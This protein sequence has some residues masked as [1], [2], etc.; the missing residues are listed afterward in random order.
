MYATSVLLSIKQKCIGCPPPPGLLTIVLN[1][2]NDQS[3]SLS[4]RSS[5]KQL[6]VKGGKPHQHQHQHQH[7]HNQHPHQHHQAQWNRAIPALEQAEGSFS[8]A[9]KKKK[10]KSQSDVIIGEMRSLLNKVT[11]ENYD[12]LI[13]E[14]KK[15][16]HGLC[17]YANELEDTDKEEFLT[18]ISKLFVRKAQVDHAFGKYYA[19]LAKATADL[20]DVFAD[21]LYEVCRESIPTTKYDADKKKN[22][23]G[24]L[25]LLV[26]LRKNQII[27]SDN[28]CATFDRL[29]T[30]IE[31]CDPS[32]VYSVQDTPINPAEQTE[33][34]IDIIVTVLP[35]YL[36]V[37]ST[38]WTVKHLQ[39]L[40]ALQDQT[41]RLKQR[42][43][44]ILLDFFKKIEPK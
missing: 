16:H 7:H 12:V 37:E 19:G 2:N 24:A 27:T 44:F 35:L 3:S 15:D 10:D 8:V 32:T 41:G 29:I 30:A 42:S 28:I 36:S 34:C 31:R 26:E 39:K 5:S 14:I 33:L 43:K 25:I 18:E 4:K 38:E 21:I 9:R 13:D 17:A 22:Y 1:G 20:I 11:V 23:I 6:H 40:R